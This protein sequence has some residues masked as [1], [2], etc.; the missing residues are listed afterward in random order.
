MKGNG[1]LNTCVCQTN[2]DLWQLENL[3]EC[4]DAV[5]VGR[6]CVHTLAAEDGGGHSPQFVAA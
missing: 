6:E 5:G 2:L 1:A 4:I 3:W